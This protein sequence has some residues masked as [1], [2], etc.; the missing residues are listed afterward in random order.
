MAL[1]LAMMMGV[2]L[3]GFR[4]V[5]RGLRAVSGG[6]FAHDGQLDLLRPLH[7][8][9]R[10]GDDDAQPFRDVLLPHDDACLRDFCAA[11]GT[12][13][14]SRWQHTRF[15]QRKNVIP[16]CFA[17]TFASHRDKVSGIKGRKPKRS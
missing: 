10:P 6:A 16:S 5:M 13:R 8:A 12:P 17:Q 3:A 15:P 14:D 2:Q 4:T 7:S 9:W 11:C 1:F